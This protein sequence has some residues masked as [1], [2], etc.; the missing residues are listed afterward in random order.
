MPK[1]ALR[2]KGYL[3]HGGP[4]LPS[5]SGVYEDAPGV[6]RQAPARR[7]ENTIHEEPGMA[8]CAPAMEM[9]TEAGGA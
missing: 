7:R 1:I 6:P 8:A 5:R 2:D 9:E 3:S 4:V